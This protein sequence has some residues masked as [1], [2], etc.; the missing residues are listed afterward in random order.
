MKWRQ[1]SMCIDRLWKTRFLVTA[2]ADMLSQ[3]IIVRTFCSGCKS[4]R[5]IL[6]HIASHATSVAKIYSACAEDNATIHCF[7]EDQDMAFE[8]T[9]IWLL[10]PCKKNICWYAL[11]VI[12][13]S[14]PVTICVT[15]KHVVIFFHMLESESSSCLEIVEDLRSNYKI[16][17]AWFEHEPWNETNMVDDI[18][19]RIREIDQ[20]ANQAPIDLPSFAAFHSFPLE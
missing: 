7:R 16:K 3:W 9:K 19:P 13:R 12:K 11:S 5:I 20:E 8:K 14:C 4:E 10:C 6:R 2:I 17:F 1:I 15:D 18:R